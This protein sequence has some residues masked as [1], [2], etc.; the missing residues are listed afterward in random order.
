MLCCAMTIFAQN[1]NKISYQAVVRNNANELVANK[2]VNV[3]VT[4][5]DADNHSYTQEFTDV[6]T[7]LN[8]LISL[9]IGPDGDN[10]AWNSIHWNHANV[11]TSVTLAGVEV[12]T[13]TMPLT[14]V[15]Y[16]LYADEINPDGAVAQAITAKMKAD[17][18]ALGAL[19]DANAADINEL[20]TVDAGLNQRIVADSN[21]LVALKNRV[22][23]FNTNVCD[24]VLAC[25]VIKDMRDSIQDNAAAIATKADVANVYS[26]GDMDI[27]LGKKADTAILAKVAKTG[28]YNDLT[29]I[30]TNLAYTTVSNTFTGDNNFSGSNTFGGTNTT[31]TFNGAVNFT[32]T[33]NA[34]SVSFTCGTNNTTAIDLCTLLTT[35][36]GEISTMSTAITNLQAANTALSARITADSSKLVDYKAK[37]KADSSAMATRITN[38]ENFVNAQNIKMKQET[39]TATAEQTS[40]T[41]DKEAK[42]DCVVRMY[43]NGV[44]V[45]GNHNGVVTV[46]NANGHATVTYVPA[47]NGNNELAA[48]DKVTIV[49]WYLP[50]TTNAGN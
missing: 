45:G 18:I 11:V 23:T 34:S 38:L 41:L 39:F 47:E 43:I 30:P 2:M 20:K 24:S 48:G 37:V 29:N 33:V 42:T 31:T 21:R 44:M 8:G 28:N 12:G 17:S 35:L 19:I 10:A 46:A 36:Q 16:A 1:N 49:Y 5:T 4:I 7:N 22:N 3:T 13:L 15:P 40:F 14:A 50:E 25:G 32:G 26:K 27:L 9:M 6:Q